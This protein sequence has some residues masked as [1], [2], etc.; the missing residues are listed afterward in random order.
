MNKGV[1][2]SNTGISNVCD[3]KYL[4]KDLCI[5]RLNA[6][7][8]EANFRNGCFRFDHRRLHAREEAS[9]ACG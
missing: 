2:D 3:L 6:G 5:L 8:V 7:I 9:L 1:P 4:S